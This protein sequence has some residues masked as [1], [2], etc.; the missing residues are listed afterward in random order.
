VSR[1][2]P[3]RGAAPEPVDF[4]LPSGR[5]HA[6]LRGPREGRL[7]LCLPG[8]SANLRGFDV[9]A[10]RLAAGGCRVAALDLRGRGRSTVSPPGTYGWPAH[11]RDV[12]IVLDT[13]GRQ[14]AA[15]VGW[16]MGAYV[17]LQLAAEVPGRL[18]RVVLI[19]ACSP[20]S[21]DFLALIRL[22]VDRLGTTFPSVDDFLSRMRALPTIEQWGPFWE[23][24]FEYDLI[25][26][27]GGGVRART[28]REAVAEDLAYIEAHD[29]RPLWSALT[30]PALLLRASRPL[31]PNGP[32]LVRPP[33]VAE[34][35]RRVPGVEVIEIDANHYGIAAAPATA[36]AVA[37][38]LSGQ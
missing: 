36:E 20:P 29:S 37:R 30:M 32:F 10:D 27:G 17:T 21:E 35:R 34:L 18:E 25:Q 6:E 7:V 22:A 11:A 26:E 33:D 4:Y 15:A 31:I 9:I 38:F 1:S 13:L 2:S 24:Y 16:S 5:L 12:A 14:R 8:L 3:D 19:D 28:S 23:R